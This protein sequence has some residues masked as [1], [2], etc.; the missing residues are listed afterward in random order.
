MLKITNRITGLSENLGWG[1]G[2]EEP[3]WGLGLETIRME[4]S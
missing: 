3:S 1:A 2:I 4:P